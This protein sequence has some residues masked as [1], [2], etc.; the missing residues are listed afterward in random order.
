MVRRIGRRP[1]TCGSR[2]ALVHFAFRSV[3]APD[4][5]GRRPLSSYLH[6]CSMQS[7]P[8]R[9]IFVRFSSPT[10]ERALTV[11]AKPNELLEYIIIIVASNKL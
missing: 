11:A 5:H 2:S 7:C 1:L 8:G 6:Y 4:S 9:P 3:V 10:L